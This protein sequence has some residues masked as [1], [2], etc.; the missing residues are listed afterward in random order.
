MANTLRRRCKNSHTLHVGD[1]SAPLTGMT[2]AHT[3][4][5]CL[6]NID[7][8]RFLGAMECLLH[9][10]PYVV[11]VIIPADG[12]AGASRTAGEPG[13]PEPPEISEHL[14]EHFLR[15]GVLCRPTAAVR[16][17]AVPGVPH[18]IIQ[19]TLPVVAE[20]LVGVRQLL[21]LLLVA[22][23]L[24]GVVLHRQL[25]V[26]LANLL[27]GRILRNPKVTIQLGHVSANAYLFTC[28]S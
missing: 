26:R 17:L 22:T 14:L 27:R 3:R 13:E 19:R 4:E 7:L 25:A 1:H 9:A 8:H 12:A 24:I 11:L 28:V 18:L 15:T 20:D 6:P 5:A 10:N 23:L 21:E 16:D 2:G